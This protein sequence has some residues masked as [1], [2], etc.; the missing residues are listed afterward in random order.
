MVSL[1]KDLLGLDYTLHVG[2]WY[3]SEALFNYLY[4]NQ[5][6]ATGTAR[7][8]RMQ[9][10]NSLINEKS[11]KREFSFRRNE[12][13]LELRYQDKKEIYMLSTMHKADTINVPRR[14]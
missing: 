8:N 2:K 1:V 11:K 10:P 14:N 12:N 4:E 9:L 3:T 6:C 5:T 13:I 7:K